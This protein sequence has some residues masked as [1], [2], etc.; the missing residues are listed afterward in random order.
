MFWFQEH[1]LI[2]APSHHWEVSVLLSFI[3]EHFVFES[4]FLFKFDDEFALVL[5]CLSWNHVMIITSRFESCYWCLPG[6]IFVALV[7]FLR[8]VLTENLL[9][10][11]ACEDNLGALHDL[12]IFGLHV[13]LGAVKPLFA[14][15]STDLNLGVQNVFAH[16]SLKNSNLIIYY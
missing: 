14:A 3:L 7:E 1:S 5:R 15:L 4:T 12:V 2:C 13:A 16:L 10:L 11:F 8:D 9:A 6:A